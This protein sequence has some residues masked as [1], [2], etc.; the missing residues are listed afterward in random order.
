[1]AR[2]KRAP[3]AVAKTL[4]DT[5]YT[6]WHNYSDITSKLVEISAKHPEYT[7][8]IPSIGE[9]T[10]ENRSISALRIGRNKP[11]CAKVALIAG[12]HAREWI[13]VGSLM[14]M[15]GRLAGDLSS[16]DSVVKTRD[17][18]IYVVPCY[19]PDGYEYSRSNKRLWRKNRCDNGDG[20]FGVDL[21]RNWDNNWC[22]YGGSRAKSYQ[23]YCGEG[24]FSEPETRAMSKWINST[25]FDALV[26]IH[27]YAGQILRPYGYKTDKSPDDARLLALSN[28][29]AGDVLEASGSRRTSYESIRGVDLYPASGAG[30]DWS[31]EN[32]GIPTVLTIEVAGEDFVVGE[33]EI[34]MRGDELYPAI[35]RVI[36]ENSKPTKYPLEDSS[37]PGE[38]SS[39]SSR[40][41]GASRNAFTGLLLIIAMLSILV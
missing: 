6:T 13:G 28:A 30:D 38:E 1:M 19:N 41:S 7:T 4:N 18:D 12:E 36:R 26:D 8:F 11:N 32:A 39:K 21:N 35:L 25:G 14:W 20:S 2:A 10:H 3:R 9:L 5:W 27:S 33:N 34:E 37:Y 23:T 31:Y 24:P 40:T 29:M 17:V 22:V 15:L 16:A